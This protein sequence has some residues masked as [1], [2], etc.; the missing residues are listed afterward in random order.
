MRTLL[1]RHASCSLR[2]WISVQ[3]D[4]KIIFIIRFTFELATRDSVGLKPLTDLLAMFGGWPMTLDNWG[5]QF[6]W[7][8]A[9]VASLQLFKKN[10]FLYVYNSLDV[11]DTTRNTIYVSMNNCGCRH[12]VIASLYYSD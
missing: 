3:L 10:Y 5:G 6:N 7:K 1:M 11:S 4:V 8:D 9:T 12:F 2:A